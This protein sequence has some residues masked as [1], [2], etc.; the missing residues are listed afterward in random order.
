MAQAEVNGLS[1]ET[2]LCIAMQNKNRFYTKLPRKRSK[3]ILR[4]ALSRKDNAAV[5]LKKA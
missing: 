2:F 5:V 1:M 4:V 3:I